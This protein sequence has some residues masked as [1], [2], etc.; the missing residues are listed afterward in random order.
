MT[1]A[2][3]VAVGSVRSCS[4]WCDDAAWSKRKNTI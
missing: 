3:V 2:G 1:D 4:V